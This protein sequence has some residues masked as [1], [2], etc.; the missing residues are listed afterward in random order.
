VKP[1]MSSANANTNNCDQLLNRFA[2]SSKLSVDD[3]SDLR[4][5]IFR[6]SRRRTFPVSGSSI[7]EMSSGSTSSVNRLLDPL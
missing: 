7:R 2:G 1:P 3:V 4:D 5:F 6:V